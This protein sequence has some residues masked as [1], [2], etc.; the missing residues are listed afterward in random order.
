[1][2]LQEEGWPLGLEPLN[3]RVGLAR[4]LDVNGS[5][6]FNALLTVSPTSS[7]DSSSDL[8]TESTGSFFPDKSITLGSLIGLSNVLDLSHRS[9]RGRLPEPTR[10]KKSYK[11]KSCFFSLCSKTTDVVSTNTTSSLGHFLEEER[12][13]ASNYRRNQSPGAY[14][15]DDFNHIVSDSEANS[16]FIGG[17]VAPPQSS[18]WLDSDAARNFNATLF[19]RGNGDRSRLFF[20]C[21]CGR[22]TH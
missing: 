17:H 2:A 15:P 20:S 12:R 16:L 6:S 1:M 11:H 14:G 4:N 7:N 13:A 22:L 5:L 21:L 19:D 10:N 8:D 18:S 9:T 3:G